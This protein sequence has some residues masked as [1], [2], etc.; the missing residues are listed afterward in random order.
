MKNLDEVL[1]LFRPIKPVP[2]ESNK[3]RVGRKVG[4]AKHDSTYTQIFKQ[5]YTIGSK[6]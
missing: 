4:Q 2:S 3:F 1:N 6:R 5:V